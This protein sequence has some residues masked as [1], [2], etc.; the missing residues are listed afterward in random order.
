MI[1]RE[2]L[3]MAFILLAISIG[4]L[5]PELSY[6]GGAGLVSV[7]SLYHM[8]RFLDVAMQFQTGH[9]SY[10]QQ[11]FTMNNSGRIDNA[12][13]G[14]GNAYLEGF[15]LFLVNF[16]GI[17]WYVFY[18]V[19]VNF[20]G[21]ASM[22]YMCAR[23]GISEKY[24]YL[25]GIF[26]I[27]ESNV[28][29]GFTMGDLALPYAMM[30]LVVNSLLILIREKKV[31][32][33]GFV[34]AFS[35]LAQTNPSNLVIGA[36]IYVLAFIF[37]SFFHIKRDYYLGVLK[38]LF[39]GVLIG[40]LVNFN[41]IGGIIEVF[42]GN[43]LVPANVTLSPSQFNDHFDF[44]TLDAVHLI[45]GFSIALFGICVYLW[46]KNYWSKEEKITK[47]NLYF[48]IFTTI[49]FYI[50]SSGFLNVDTLPGISILQAVYRFNII[51]WMFALYF[52][53]YILTKHE[54]KHLNLIVLSVLILT[55]FP[56]IGA[57]VKSA[58][59][60]YNMGLMQK[61]INP[62]DSDRLFL[63]LTNPKIM[64]EAH[65]KN[66]NYNWEQSFLPNY[67]KYQVAYITTPSTRFLGSYL[68]DFQS[69]I[70]YQKGFQGTNLQQQVTNSGLVLT[71]DSS[72]NEK[73]TL[74]VIKYRHTQV[75]LNGKLL[76][77]KEMSL[78]GIGQIEVNAKK[79]L[80]TMQVWYQ[81]AKWFLVGVTFQVVAVVVSL[82]YLTGKAF[83]KRR[84]EREK[85]K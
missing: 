80:N 45:N 7:D 21:I 68:D 20:I 33:A 19:L 63:E 40:I 78:S 34:V 72:K 84:G 67:T 12:L 1:T 73:T 10:F 13:Y 3:K 74:P 30:P 75:K 9:F 64:I 42:S 24:A 15:I 59:D 41:V 11:F 36:F 18:S 23:N 65:Y 5:I 48:I 46:L 82:I 43:K 6:G 35:L 77:D 56:Y 38:Q 31:N 50:I 16:H 71:W 14:P 44:T 79:G 51:S 25:I 8:T 60:F 83:V 57:T 32:I 55:L 76:P 81:P 62:P 52:I 28:T 4:L 49:L 54:S 26:F 58:A 85:Q 69:Q 17:I 66:T 37:F 29:Q 22:Y 61:N 47:L 2:K 70:I 53:G 27:T 39:I